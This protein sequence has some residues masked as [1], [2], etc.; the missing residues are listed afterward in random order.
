MARSCPALKWLAVLTLHRLAGGRGLRPPMRTQTV[1]RARVLN[2]GYLLQTE[3]GPQKKKKSPSPRPTPYPWASVP[4]GVT[5]GAH[6]PEVALRDLH[7]LPRKGRHTGFS[8]RLGRA[9]VQSPLGC[10]WGMDG[11]TW[12]TGASS[13]SQEG[14][15][16][17]VHSGG[18]RT[19][20]QEGAVDPPRARLSQ[21]S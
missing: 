15:M 6:D 3:W 8:Q 4:A 13:T 18:S 21:L 5:G 16:E 10:M 1:H 19:G 7:P 20:N 9:E 11:H 17:L 2:E 14:H 12:T